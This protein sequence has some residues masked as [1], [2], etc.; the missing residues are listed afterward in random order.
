VTD[1]RT[2]H[3]ALPD[4]K[5]TTLNIDCNIMWFCVLNYQSVL[6]YVDQILI[7]FV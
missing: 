2:Y 5:E 1:A 7:V 6:D 3:I 4:K